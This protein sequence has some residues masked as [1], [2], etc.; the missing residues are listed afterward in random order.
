M[1]KVQA[2]NYCNQELFLY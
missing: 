1:L 2:Y